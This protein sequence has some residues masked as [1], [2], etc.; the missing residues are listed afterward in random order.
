MTTG[1]AEK[2]RQARTR[3]AARVSQT[4]RQAAKLVRDLTGLE[5]TDTALAALEVVA[6][7]IVRRLTPA[8]AN[9]FISQLPSE[10]QEPLLDLPAGPD[11]GISRQTVEADLAS[12][13]SLSLA[14]A[15]ALAPAVGLAIR[16]LVNRG[17][18]DQVLA[19]LPRE[20]R[21]LLPDEVAHQT[22]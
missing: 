12:R 1:N 13:L 16:S 21:G 5:D 8:E 2:S 15:E 6:G 19:Q 11:P 9:D 10:L 3:H 7:G 20:M 4:S 18:I 17:E 14:N 22:P